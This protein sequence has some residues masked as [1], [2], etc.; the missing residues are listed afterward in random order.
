MSDKP[1][2]WTGGPRGAE[3][4]VETL[5]EENEDLRAEVEKLA[6][7]NQRLRDRVDELEDLAER[8]ELIGQGLRRVNDELDV[9]EERLED[10]TG[11]I[12]A[13]A[14]R[15]DDLD[16]RTRLQEHVQNASSLKVPER[17][18]I[19]IQTLFNQAQKKR[20][21]G[22]EPIATMDYNGADDAL[23]GT[24]YRRQLLDAMERAD[25][26]VPGDVLQFKKEPRSSRM[27]SRLI[28]DLNSGELPSTVAGKKIDGGLGD[29]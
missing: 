4:A 20:R 26:L 14:E 6:A 25:G 1:D 29:E 7:R 2:T 23:G 11:R 5:V 9:R 16:D 15:V 17:A 8:V 13:L 19:C 28:L 24:L 27:N 18:A 12:L 10:Q 3:A 22:G 21:R